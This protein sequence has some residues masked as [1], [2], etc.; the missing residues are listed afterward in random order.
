MKFSKALF[1]TFCLRFICVSG[2]FAQVP[3]TGDDA[4]SKAN[5]SVF[6]VMLAKTGMNSLNKRLGDLRNFNASDNYNGI[7]ARG[8]ISGISLLNLYNSSLTVKGFEF[9]YDHVFNKDEPIKLFTGIT[10]GYLGTGNARTEISPINKSEGSGHAFSLGIYG[11]LMHKDGWF[12]DFTLRNFWTSFD[13]SSV[14]ALGRADYNP[15]D[16]VLALSAQ[17]GKN[18][19]YPLSNSAYLRFEPKAG[20]SYIQSGGRTVT[21]SPGYALKYESLNSLNGRL[22][23][24]TAYVFKAGKNLLEPFIEL[25]YNYEFDAKNTISVL[26]QIYRVDLSGP[27][28]ELNA[29]MNIQLES[30][31]YAYLQAGVQTG[32]KIRTYSANLGLRFGFGSKNPANKASEAAPA[33]AS[34]KYS[35]DSDEDL[36]STHPARHSSD[37]TPWDYSS[38]KEMFQPVTA[39]IEE[40]VSGPPL[41]LPESLIKYKSVA[42]FPVNSVTVSAAD[43]RKITEIA[44]YIKTLNYKKVVVVGH[45][46]IDGDSKTN[47]KLSY[48]RAQAAA[49]V[50]AEAGIPKDKIE[51]L[52]ASSDMPAGRNSTAEGRQQNRRVDINVF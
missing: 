32:D 45:T 9:G 31:L 43:K 18:F 1:F 5:A 37:Y 29:G 7:W 34:Y 11:T 10:A 27:G 30:N 51:I 42:Q 21:F 17:T 48:L 23:F 38:P 44:R 33:F 8:M 26:P 49:I 47:K 25:A 20:L 40:D 15:T 22:A 52:N 35:A 19:K 4:A 50:L 12:A 2:L 13:M 39:K 41:K 6:P 46:D 3:F 14:S 24:L 36:S 28:F 16:N